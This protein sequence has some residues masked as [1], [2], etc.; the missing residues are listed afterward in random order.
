M[1]ALDRVLARTKPDVVVL[2]YGM[3][4][5]I[6][7]PFSEERFKKYQDGMTDV[8]DRV[9][10]AGAKRGRRYAAAVRPAAGQGQAG[11]ED[12]RQVQLGEAV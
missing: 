11:A 10:K 1:N 6:Y 7:Y 3:N 4:D 5:G 2:C 8:I 9:T 12:G